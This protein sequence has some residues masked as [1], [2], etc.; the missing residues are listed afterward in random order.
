MTDSEDRVPKVEETS[1]TEAPGTKDG[2]VQ[3]TLKRLA[4]EG[5]KILP[6]DDPFYSRGPSIIFRSRTG[7]SSSFRPQ[8]PPPREDRSL[9][10][11]PPDFKC[12]FTN[13]GNKVPRGVRRTPPCDAKYL[14]TVGWHWGP[15]NERYDEYYLTTSKDGKS[16]LLYLRGK[17]EIWGKPDRGLLAAYGPRTAATEYEAAVH[18][19]ATTWRDDPD[20][21]TAGIFHEVH[22][23]GFLTENQL[24]DIGQL[25]EG[26]SSR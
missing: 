4:A 17:D 6:P 1:P 26:E 11:C 23:E 5:E 16:W 24:E 20:R 19:L 8:P 10:A 21:G 12:I 3:A 25:V 15:F 2:W 18:L 13:W 14:G 7:G 9:P 22:G